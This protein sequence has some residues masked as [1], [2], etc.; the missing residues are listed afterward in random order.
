MIYGLLIETSSVHCSVGIS[1]KGV[2]LEC[3]EENLGMRHS[4]VLHKWMVECLQKVRID[5]GNLSYIGIGTGPGSYTGLRIGFSAAKGLAYAL[6][7]P[8]VGICSA[9]C[10]FHQMVGGISGCRAY[11]MI[12]AGRMEVYMAE[13]EEGGRR[14]SGPEPYILNDGFLE[15]ISDGTPVVLAGNGINKILHKIHDKK[16]IAVFPSL[17]PSV[18]GLS[19]AIFEKYLRREYMDIFTCEPDYLKEYFFKSH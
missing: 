19:G 10:I 16:N 5:P 18:K 9:D 6:Q 14:I 8:L 11:V 1:E 3:K 12:D 15:K 2:L 13:Y 7:I 17:L 4:E